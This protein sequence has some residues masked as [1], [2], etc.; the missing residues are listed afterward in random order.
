MVRRNFVIL[1]VVALMVSFC[2][3]PPEAGDLQTATSE[4]EVETKSNKVVITAVVV[5]AGVLVCY[6]AP[7]INTKCKDVVSRAWD[8]SKGGV[9]SVTNKIGDGSKKLW[10]GVK[11]PFS[12]K[13]AKQ[14]TDETA[15]T[16]ADSAKSAGDAPNTQGKKISGEDADK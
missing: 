12:K 11:K 7:G 15:E 8:S 14:G 5:G 1:V 4:Q 13:S 2:G 3:T 16:V 9:T 6:L 10:D